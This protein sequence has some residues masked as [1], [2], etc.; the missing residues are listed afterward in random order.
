MFEGGTTNNYLGTTGVIWDK[1]SFFLDQIA[2]K[3]KVW[4]DET[5]SFYSWG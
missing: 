1:W 5:T 2:N 3:Y 4:F